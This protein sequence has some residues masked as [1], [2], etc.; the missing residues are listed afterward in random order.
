MILFLDFDGTTHP[1][2]C[3]IFKEFSCLPRIERVLREFPHV[4]VVISSWW[5]VSDNLDQLRSYFS[6]DI[7]DRVI[8]STPVIET[9]S[10][11]ILDPVPRHHEILQ[12]IFENKYTGPWVALDDDWRGFP[13]DC[14]ELIKCFPDVGVDAEIEEKLR[15][16]F[17]SHEAHH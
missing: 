11:V 4:Q 8:G 12:W 15:Q 1:Y 17:N 16:Y 10:N 7:K 2:G 6:L 14:K 9:H 13:D 5:R 3:K